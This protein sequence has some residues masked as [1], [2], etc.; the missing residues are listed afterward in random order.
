MADYDRLESLDDSFLKLEGLDTPMHVGALSVF[1][2]EP[3]LDDEGRF[4]LAEAREMVA[5]R[6][7]LVPRFRKRLMEVPLDLDRPIW[8]DDDSFDIAYHVRLTALPRPGTWDQLA[9]LTTR[10]QS[11]LL[12]R[13]RPLWEIWF[14][15]GLE[16]NR[17][18]LIQKTHHALVDGASGVDVATVL[19]D[20]E[21]EP[22]VLD[23]PEWVSEPPPSPAGL[24]VD[25][26][27]EQVTQPAKLIERVGSFLRAPVRALER[28]LGV[29]RS[30]STMLGRDT[31]APRTSLNQAVGRHRRFDVVR[32][33]L[34]DAKAARRELGGTVN[35]VVL[36]AVGSGLARLFENRGES[37]EHVRAMIPVSVRAGDEHM[38]LGNRVSAMFVNL[39]VVADGPLD[40]LKSI[41]AITSELKDRH[42]AVGAEFLVGL[43]RY[44]APTLLSLASRA[45]HNQPF[46]N[47]VITNVPGPQQPLYTLG[48]RMLE[49][50][51]IVPLAHNLTVGIAILSYDG[52]LDIGVFADR[53]AA[54]DVEVLTAGIE[55]GFAELRKLTE[56]RAPHSA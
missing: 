35:D 32:V 26:L 3:L 31:V 8:V 7:H 53:D 17:V 21:R 42:Q 54:P 30:L 47:L 15:E 55:N 48:A 9:T 38:Q 49:A 45:V 20:F 36:S 56:E 6:L 5:S 39:P 40:R 16:D 27:R 18:A 34:D 23:P 14:V 10:V 46:F 13:A 12:D 4:R 11:Q 51:P 52:Q 24:L 28:G 1:E 43:T 29:A 22:T 19:L 44:A 2:G 25:S 50:F 33:P 37:P 41:G